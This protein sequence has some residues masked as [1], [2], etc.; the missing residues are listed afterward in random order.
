MSSDIKVDDDDNINVNKRGVIDTSFD[1]SPSSSGPSSKCSKTEQVSVSPSN[2]VTEEFL[3]STLK[4]MFSDFEH[5]LELKLAHINSRL[6]AI[7]EAA[8]SS[9]IRIEN[10]LSRVDVIE[11]REAEVEQRMGSVES[12]VVPIEQGDAGNNWQPAG[13][14]ETKILL[15]GDSNS[16]GKIKFGQ[17]R[18]TMGSA[19][20]GS[21]EFC[22]KFEDLPP[23]D[24]NRFENI[25][26]VVLSVGTNNIKSETCEAETLVKDMHNY[27]KKVT[28]RHPGLHVLLPGI[29]PIHSSYT[30][31]AIHVKI[32]WY[33]HYL[34]DMCNNMN[35]VSF[36]DV[37]VFSD[38]SNC[39]KPH[40][41]GGDSDPLHLN[42]GGVRLFAS[43]LKYVLRNKHGLPQITRRPPESSQTGVPSRGT[44][45]Y[46]PSNTMRGVRGG[47]WP[48]RRG[49]RARN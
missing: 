8:S 48:S 40:L 15:L 16:A 31:Q 14:P 28:S 12:A 44:D 6:D 10:L 46:Q 20:P 21:S 49:S 11:Q 47:R 45:N 22:P 35:R 5:R 39:L 32:Q 42:E 36:V 26:D 1:S 24:S 18:G 29:L 23:F 41:C 43:R 30:D 33:N 27:V 25:S 34:K 13:S 37:G 3:V 9:E 19:L 38:R 2:L 7:E 4:T 17:E